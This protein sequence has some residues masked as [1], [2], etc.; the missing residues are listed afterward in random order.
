MPRR[1]KRKKA[2]RKANAAGLA[3]SRR[4]RSAGG[5][6]DVVWPI[7]LVVATALVYAD[8]F[9]GSFV[10]DNVHHIVENEQIRTLFPPWHLLASRRP[11]VELSLAVNY[12]VGG[13]DPWGYHLFNTLVHVCAGLLLFGVLGQI[14]ADNRRPQGVRDAARPLAFCCALLWLVHPL[15]TQSVTYIIQRGE[16]L[17]GLFYLATLYSVV[18]GAASSRPWR[19]YAC[20][21]VAC[22][23]GMCSKAVMVTAP[24]VVLLVDALLLADG[25]RDALRKRWVLYLGLA[26]TWLL[27][28]AL[29]IAGSVLNPGNKTATVGFGSPNVAWWQYLL[30]E[31]WVLL[32][33]LRL[34][35]WPAGQCLDYGWPLTKSLGQAIVPGVVIVALLLT[36]VVLFVRRHWM[37]AVGVWFFVILAPT[38]SFIPIQDPIYEHRMYLPLA[39]VVVLIV[40]GAFAWLSRRVGAAAGK[41][42]VVGSVVAAVALGVVGA[43]RNRVYA[44]PLATWRDVVAKRPENARA[45]YN[46]G[47]ELQEAGSEAESLHEYERALELNPSFAL[48]YNNV[49]LAR[50]KAGRLDEAEKLFRKGISLKPDFPEA[51][52]NLASILLHRGRLDEAKTLLE[53]VTVLDPSN[54][55]AHNNLGLVYARSQEFAKAITEFEKALTCDPGLPTVNYNLGQAL[56]DSGRF[57]EAA[58]HFARELK[59]NPKHPKAAM[60]LEAAKRRAAGG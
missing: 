60:M 31:P 55:R 30:T 25:F 23:L 50:M 39:A 28:M 35:V 13:L 56:A 11:V 14:F 36:T 52:A 21:I 33:Y 51:M 41:Y 46:L 34:S 5:V 29:G 4:G 53:R 2:D 10:Y 57:A 32:R 1:N 27:L 54:A 12:A 9:D 43:A 3:A 6:P 20:A 22:A 16:S 26:A 17:M 42:V 44:T 7:V 58:K 47:H 49:G 48:P 45:H 19:W 37:A 15:Q 18:R 8:S 24:V 40:V 38:S 59:I